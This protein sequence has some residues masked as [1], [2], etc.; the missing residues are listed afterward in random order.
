MGEGQTPLAKIL[1]VA[2]REPSHKIQFVFWGSSLFHNIITD[3]GKNKKAEH[4]ST[5]FPKSY[6]E[7]NLLMLWSSKSRVMYA[8]EKRF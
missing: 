6:H 5:F 4:S 2:M 1:S 7:L 8:V 3:L